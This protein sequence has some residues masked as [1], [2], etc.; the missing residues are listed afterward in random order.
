M[1]TITLEKFQSLLRELF[2]FDCADLDFGIYRIMNLKRAVI[3]RFIAEDLPKEIAEELQRGA[4]AEQERAQQT[5]KEVRQKLLD[6]LGEDALDANGNLAEKYRETRAGREYLEA[7]AKAAGGRSAEALEADVYN[8]L[9]AFFSRYWQ[10]GDF[11]SKRRYSKKERYAIPYNGEEVYL[12]WANHDQYYVKTGEYFTDY[13][14]QA[15]N[16][17]TVQ[18]K[19]KQADVEQNNVKGEK[20]FFLPRLDEIS[21]DE[22]ARLLTIPFEFRPLTEQE[23]IAFGQKNQQESII[24]KAVAEIP[25]RVQAADALAALL[26]ERRKTEK[27]ETVTCLEHHLRQYTRRNTSDFFIHKDLRGF[28]SRELDFYLKNEVLNLDEMEA[29][30]EGLAEGWFQLMRLIKR[31]GLKIVE[32]LA[33]IEDFQK[34]LWEKKKF[35]TETFYV[36]AVGNIPEAFYPEVAANDPQWEEWEQLGM[37][38]AECRKMTA[39]ERSS[40][41]MHHSSLPLDTRHF[42]PEF[43]DRLLASFQNLDE[44]TDGL[45]VH[46]ENW[47]ALNLLQEKYRERVK[48]IY[49]DPPYNTG[50]D[51]FLYK[52]SYQHSCWL[53]MM[54]QRLSLSSS[55]LES[56]GCLFISIDDI[57]FPALRYMLQHLFREDT[58]ISELVWKK[59]SGGDMTAG[60]GARLSVDHDYV[61]A[62]LTEGASG[63]SGLPI[64]EEDYTNPDNDPDGPWTTGDLTCNKTAEERPNLFYDLIDPTTGNVFKCNPKRVWAYEPEKM[65]QFIERTVNGRWLPKVL[66]PSDPTKRPKLKVFLKERERATRLFSSWMEEVPLNAKATRL[67]DNILGQRVLLYPKPV[68]LIESLARQ[69][70]MNEADVVL[71]YFAGSGTTGHAVINLNR[72]DGGRRKFILVEMAQYFDTVLLPRIKKVT[73]TPEWKDGKPRRMATAEEAARSP[74]IV[75]VIRL[76]SYEDAL[77]NLTFDEE[78][79]QQALDLFGQEY[80]LSYM[81]KW[82]TRRSETLLNVAQ[83]QSPFSYKLHI[84]RDGETR[85]QPVDLPETF[86]YLLGLD[87][88]TRKVYRNDERRMMN[89]ESHHSSFITHHSYLVYRGALRDG[90]SVAVIWRETKGWTT[91]DYRRDAAFVSEQKLAEGADEVWVNGDALIP[92]AR[93]LDPIFKERMMNAE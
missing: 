93:S 16:G 68:E 13:T 42:P 22:P 90:R 7:Q 29:A 15:P 36:V 18:F 64:S 82:E 21:W 2:Q 11:I 48:C 27:G 47:Q 79:G 76:E 57:E 49:I 87:V 43:T 86:A 17:V 28:L 71:D 83:L 39:E 50:N 25:K 12:Y 24:A 53:S 59:R 78:S 23:N 32:F 85:E 66:F 35:V 63:F 60:R 45:L 20:R 33:Q 34:A 75:K 9:Y 1:K 56:Q 74:R 26:A 58:I 8:R 84:H 46:S 19:L 37:V 69:T 31:I 5:L 10:E 6:V 41:L 4:F 81:L 44:M 30:G 77:N 54:S 61:V 3:E 38:N 62:A 72:K 51:E 52:D 70:L 67:L 89:D 73:F 92:G 40:F 65:K 91:E 55:Y 88:Q 14:Y 80:L